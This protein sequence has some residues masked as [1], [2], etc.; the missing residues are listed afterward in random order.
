VPGVIID[1]DTMVLLSSKANIG[2]RTIWYQV[3]SGFDRIVVHS[4]SERSKD[5][6][7]AY[8]ILEQASS[9]S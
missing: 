4:S 3:P 1:R 7:V 5:T 8:P 2:Q 6:P 9:P